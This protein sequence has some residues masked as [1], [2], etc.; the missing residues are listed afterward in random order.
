MRT[1]VRII[2]SAT[3]PSAFFISSRRIGSNCIL[4]LQLL[5][6]LQ[7][8]DVVE[9]LEPADTVPYRRGVSGFLDFPQH[10]EDDFGSRVYGVG[11]K[12]YRLETKRFKLRQRKVRNHAAR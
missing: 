12:P 6:L 4:F 10:L 9:L 11:V 3:D 8:A 5:D 1:T 2:S 7:T